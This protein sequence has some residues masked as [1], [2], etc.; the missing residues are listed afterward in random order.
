M[1]QTS[2]APMAAVCLKSEAVR[3]EPIA[4]FDKHTMCYCW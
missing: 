4:H 2:V 3:A 1:N